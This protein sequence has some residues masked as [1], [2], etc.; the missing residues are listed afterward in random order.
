MFGP[1]LCIPVSA[2]VRTSLILGTRGLLE[3]E[4][5]Y[6]SFLGERNMEESRGMTRSPTILWGPL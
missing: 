5:D 6:S 1:A 4:G 2:A 3:G